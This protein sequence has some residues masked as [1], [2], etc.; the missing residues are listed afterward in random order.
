MPRQHA[1][2]ELE[3]RPSAMSGVLC[4]PVPVLCGWWWSVMGLDVCRRALTCYHCFHACVPGR[5]E[6]NCG[7]PW[8]AH[9]WLLKLGRPSTGRQ[10]CRPVS[11]AARGACMGW[12]PYVSCC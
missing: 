12:P 1:L 6:D 10:V 9:A 7:G 5:A 3:L 2:H 8:H 11:P 4:P